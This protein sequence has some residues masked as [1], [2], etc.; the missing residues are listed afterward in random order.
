MQVSGIV[1]DKIGNDGTVVGGP[2]GPD[3]AALTDETGTGHDVIDAH[4][5]DPQ[6][7]EPVFE[8]EMP[9]GVAVPPAGIREGIPQAGIPERAAY[10]GGIRGV[11]VTRHD[12]RTSFLSQ[13]SR[14]RL[15]LGKAG[16]DVVLEVVDRPGEIPG[17]SFRL[18]ERV[19]AS[20]RGLEVDVVEGNLSRAHAHLAAQER[21]LLPAGIGKLM[22]FGR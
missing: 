7:G 12:H 11:Q 6:P 5:G 1:E 17:V 22:D 20:S 14:H 16:C 13:V 15:G 18:P 21:F 3:P 2:A 9:V 10:Q 8:Q 19:E 4:P